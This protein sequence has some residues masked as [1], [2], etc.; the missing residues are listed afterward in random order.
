[1]LVLLSPWWL[2]LSARRARLD[3]TEAGPR[4]ASGRFQD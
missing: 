4:D 1:L 2:R 3:A